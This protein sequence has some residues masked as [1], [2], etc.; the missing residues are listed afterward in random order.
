MFDGLMQFLQGDGILWLGIFSLLL[1]NLYSFYHFSRLVRERRREVQQGLAYLRREIKDI[2]AASD[3]VDDRVRQ[4][5]K[6]IQAMEEQY[7]DLLQR[8]PAE[9]NY[10]AALSMLKEGI[11]SNKV[12]EHSGLSRGE[13]ELLQRLAF[14]ENATH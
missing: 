2:Y 1:M 8:F 7:N 12:M 13:L 3:T 11:D 5:L 6:K 10:R 14:M 4:V 9:R